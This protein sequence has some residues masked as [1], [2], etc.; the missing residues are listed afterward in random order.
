MIFYKHW[1]LSFFVKKI[2]FEDRDFGVPNMNKNTHSE[3]Y[4]VLR[5]YYLV[6]VK[7]STLRRFNLQY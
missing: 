4:Q 7:N 6:L 1:R 2:E 5:D 3:M